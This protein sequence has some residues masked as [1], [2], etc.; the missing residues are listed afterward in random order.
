MLSDKYKMKGAMP[1]LQNQLLADL[2]PKQA[3]RIFNL[4]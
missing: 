3:P 1:Q 4:E 2:L